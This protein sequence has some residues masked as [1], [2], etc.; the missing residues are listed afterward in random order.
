MDPTEATAGETEPTVDALGAPIT[1]TSPD[2]SADEPTHTV[3]W[4][5]NV[6]SDQRDVHVARLADRLAV[7]E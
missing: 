2:A 7:V 6:R 5:Q 1:D 3:P 4:W